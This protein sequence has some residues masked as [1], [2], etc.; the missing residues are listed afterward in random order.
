MKTLFKS[1]LATLVALFLSISLSGCFE[2]GAKTASS[3]AIFSGTI[4]EY[5]LPVGTG[6]LKITYCCDSSG[7]QVAAYKK[8]FKEDLEQKAHITWVY[9]DA[10]MSPQVNYLF[11]SLRQPIVVKI[12]TSLVSA[13]VVEGDMGAVA[14]LFPPTSG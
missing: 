4:R 2:E 14:T 11:S 7:E 1:V 12:D 13:V 9:D 5:K 10:R 6:S 3:G 8:I